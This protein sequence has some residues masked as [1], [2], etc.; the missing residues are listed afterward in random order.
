MVVLKWMGSPEPNYRAYTIY[1][2]S[3]GG[4][5]VRYDGKIHYVKAIPGTYQ[6]VLK[7]SIGGSRLLWKRIQ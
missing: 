6:E 7:M 1:C 4:I 3:D 5:S 2:P